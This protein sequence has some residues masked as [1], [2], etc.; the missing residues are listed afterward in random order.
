MLLRDGCCSGC[1]CLGVSCRGLC[2]CDWLLIGCDRSA[3]MS[4]TTVFLN[5]LVNISSLLLPPTDTTELLSSMLAGA[6]FVCSSSST[7]ARQ[8]A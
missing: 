7:C 1:C 3:L 5:F 6:G 2:P 4:S 8:A